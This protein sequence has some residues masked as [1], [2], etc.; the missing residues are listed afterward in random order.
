[1]PGIFRVENLICQLVSWPSPP[2]ECSWHQWAPIC[3]GFLAALVYRAFGA[4]RLSAF[5][6]GVAAFFLA[7]VGLSIATAASA[8]PFR[9]PVP[10]P[11]RLHFGAARADLWRRLS[12]SDLPLRRLEQRRRLTPPWRKFRRKAADRNRRA[13]YCG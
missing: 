6:G 13:G 9:L 10:G 11:G 7:A 12:P 1:M 8:V 5:A 3:A 4:G 2:D